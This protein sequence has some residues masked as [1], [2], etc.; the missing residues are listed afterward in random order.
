MGTSDYAICLDFL[1][2]FHDNYKYDNFGNVSDG[3]TLNRK[4]ILG[5]ALAALAY[6]TVLFWYYRT[7]Q[8]SEA[9]ILLNAS[10]DPTRELWH[11][12]NQAF[13][14]DYEKQTGKKIALKQSHG[15][16]SAQARAV[17][18]GLPADVVTLALWPDTDVL[19]RKGVIAEHWQARLPFGSLPYYSTIVFVVR[20]DNPKEIKDW[21]DLAKPGVGVITPNPKTS[22]NGK[23]SYLAAWGS[24]IERGGTEDEAQEFVAALYKNVLVLDNGA[25]GATVTFAQRKIGDVHITWENEAHL[26]ILEAPGELELIYPPSSIKAE[27]FIA[28]VDAVVERK[29]TKDAAKAYLEFLYTDAGQEIIGEHYYRPIRPE[30]LRKFDDRFP[31]IKLFPVTAVAR[32]WDEVQTKFF[33]D[34][35]LFDRI[36][37]KRK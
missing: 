21:P 28:W 25:R 2:R 15:G 33:A 30:I 1:A 31:D 23:L 14:A 9:I 5:L 18:D 26:E 3:A 11:A 37:Q 34:G 6:G 35:A 32:D 29:G 4:W 12:L 16:S 8:D 24:V 17:I 10:Y 13:M 27:P 36:Y 22:G 7:G 19:R 20:K